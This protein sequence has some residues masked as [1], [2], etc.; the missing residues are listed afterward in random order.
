MKIVA[1]VILSA[2]LMQITIK[3]IQIETLYR[4]QTIS[5]KFKTFNKIHYIFYKRNFNKLW[6]KSTIHNSKS[7]LLHWENRSPNCLKIN[8]FQS[9][10]LL[11]KLRLFNR[12]ECKTL[13]IILL[14]TVYCGSSTSS[15]LLSSKNH[16]FIYRKTDY[17]P[18]LVEK[19]NEGF[20]FDV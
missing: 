19:L 10:N 7:I 6:A 2:S 8:I 5:S 16:V 17:I 20:G 14:L 13:K 9:L 3:I 11:H 12:V 4:H 1:I 15:S 18:E